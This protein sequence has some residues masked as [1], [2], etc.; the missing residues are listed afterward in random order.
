MTS[1]VNRKFLH[2][3]YGGQQRDDATGVGSLSLMMQLE[4]ANMCSVGILVHTSI[5]AAIKNNLGIVNHPLAYESPVTPNAF[6]LRDPQPEGRGAWQVYPC[7]VFPDAT[8]TIS[9]Q[10]LFLPSSH[11]RA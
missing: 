10:H 11:D 6:E 4:H 2:D 3:Q 5:A 9:L 7:L 1:E 8:T